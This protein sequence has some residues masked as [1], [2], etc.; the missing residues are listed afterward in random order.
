M[1]SRVLHHLTIANSAPVFAQYFDLHN[2]C[3]E[4][5]WPRCRCIATPLPQLYKSTTYISAI[6]LPPLSRLSFTVNNMVQTKS[7]LWQTGT[8]NVQIVVGSDE[9]VR[10]SSI[11][12]QNAPAAKPKSYSF[13]DGSVPLFG[14]RLSG[15]G[16]PKH[17]S[18]KTLIGS[19]V[20]SRLK[21]HSWSEALIIFGIHE[22]T[23]VFIK[24]GYF[25]VT[26]GISSNSP[27]NRIN[28]L[29]RDTF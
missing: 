21:Y 2:V 8:V 19:Y 25:M 10:L 20:S 23:A 7:I 27:G 9:I 17:K 5:R 11:R 1:F 6:S 18:S 22:Y 14:A 3:K 16:N 29:D 15:E 28:T 26:L 4:L 12:P 24:F 13:G